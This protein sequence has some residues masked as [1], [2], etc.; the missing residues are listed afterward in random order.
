M[1]KVTCLAWGA[2]T[3]QGS[4]FC[5][6]LHPIRRQLGEENEEFALR[7]QQVVVNTGMVEVGALSRGEEEEGLKRPQL[8]P[9]NSP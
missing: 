2:L 7:V 3:E 9:S 8:K 4:G 1:G 6:W 5:R